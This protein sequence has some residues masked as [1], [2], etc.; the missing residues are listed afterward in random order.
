MRTFSVGEGWVNTLAYSPDSRSLIVDVRQ[1]PQRHPFMGFTVQ[2]V[3]ELVW[4]D[5][6]TGTPQRRFRLRDSLYGPG[7]ALANK[8]REDWDPGS[9]AF[10]VSWCFAPWRIA[11]AWEWTNKEDGVCVFD[12][13]SQTTVDLSVSTH[14]HVERLALSPDGSRLALATSHDKEPLSMLVAH[15][16]PPVSHLTP[17][18]PRLLPC[19]LP[20]ALTALAFNGR[21]AAMAF[22]EREAVF[23]W[24][25]SAPLPVQPEPGAD[26]DEPEPPGSPRLPEP[27]GT[28]VGFVPRC[29]AFA[30]QAPL[31]A[32]GGA[33]VTVHD[34]AAAR[35]TPLDRTG[36]VVNALA[37]AADGRWL[38][39]GTDHG[40]AELWD[41]S[42]RKRLQ[43]FDWAS[44][45]V[46]AVALAPDGFTA[47]AGTRT[48]TVVVW[49]L[50]V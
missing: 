14:I 33:G 20:F 46:T 39:L 45:P 30:T 36:P 44:G 47:A 43:A 35:W 21:V 10:D 50:D 27:P 22:A 48:G 29:L 24:D 13:D 8:G 42:A 49:D 1:R 9:P 4:W 18:R 7:G 17:G 23:L 16:L 5:W 31:L 32:A 12:V 38:L 11:A 41:V 2:P 34:L 19:E 15:V 37:L 40:T 6:M 25:F 28:E 26:E 3:A